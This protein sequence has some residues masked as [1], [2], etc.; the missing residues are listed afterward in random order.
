MKLAYFVHDL[1]DP[2]VRRRVRMLQ[3]GGAAPIVLGFRRAETAPQTIA[4]ALAIDFVVVADGGSSDGTRVVVREIASRDPRGRLIDNPGRLQSAGL[5]LAAAGGGDRPWL[6]RVDAH[7]D[8]P[9]NYASILIAEARLTGAS[10]VVVSMLSVGETPFQ[11]AA[12]AGA[13]AGAGLRGSARPAGGLASSGHAGG[14]AGEAAR[15]AAPGA[16]LLG[17]R[18]GVA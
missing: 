14:G 18:S 6:L 9:R 11:R 16:R 4:G 5:N 8:Y 15:R 7:A 2:A 1:T 13:R 10:S 12:A 17:W 3:A